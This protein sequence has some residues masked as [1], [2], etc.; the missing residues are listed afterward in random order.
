M[1]TSS[2]RFERDA[3]DAERIVVRA[4]EPSDMEA[5]AEIM[6]Q[7]GVRRGTLSLGHRTAESMA[8]WYGKQPAGGISLCAQ[9][10]G[11][12]AGH[13]GLMAA[14]FHRAHSAHLGIS[15]HDAY[16][17]RGVGR[18]LIGALID[19][20]DRSLGLR[21]LELTVFTDN[22]PAIALYRSF[23]FVEEGRMRGYAMRDGVL[24]DALYMAR[25]KNAPAFASA[26]VRDSLPH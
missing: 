1:N 17:G 10:D 18:A 26:H 9:L 14:P 3:A 20:A 11:R 7:P 23:G 24:A 5:I 21:R 13:A 22:T 8:A 6:S 25:L 4:C 2:N 15:V 16:Q 19:Y 12:I